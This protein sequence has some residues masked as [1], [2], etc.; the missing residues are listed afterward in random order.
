MSKQRDYANKVYKAALALGIPEPQ[1][2]LAAAQSSVETG[3]GKHAPGNAYFGIKAGSS[4][5]GP[6][7]ALNT[8]EEIGG[9]DITIKDAF[10]VYDDADASLADWWATLQQKWPDAATAT[11]F[12]DAVAGLKTGIHGSYATDSDYSKIVKFVDKTYLPPRPPMNIP[13]V[14]SATS[15]NPVMGLAGGAAR[16]V[17]PPLPR[18]RPQTAPVPRQRPAEPAFKPLPFPGAMKAPPAAVPPRPVTTATWAPPM[19]QLAPGN[20]DLNA[21]RVFNAP[22][23]S[24]RTENSMSIGTDAGEVLIPTVVNGRQLSEEQAIE[25]YMRTGESLGTFSSPDA[26]NRYAQ[27]L[28]ERQ[29]TRYAPPTNTL[30]PP[31][32]PLNPPMPKVSLASWPSTAQ[33]PVLTGAAGSTSASG[34]ASLKPAPAPAATQARTVQMAAARPANIPLPVT[35]APAAPVMTAAQR[36]AL[37]SVPKPSPLPAG[38]GALVGG[39]AGVVP[40]KVAPVPLPRPIAAPAA[41][42]PKYIPPQTIPPTA[43]PPN[44]NIFQS[45]F[46]NASSAVGN[47]GT[48]LGN[49]LNTAKTNVGNALPGMQQAIMDEALKAALGT[50]PGRTAIIDTAIKQAMT[51]TNKPAPPPG[52]PAGYG[53]K[54]YSV[55]SAK[56]AMPWAF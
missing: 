48:S 37:A 5:D 54:G 10:R 47:M 14:A 19:G 26:A 32:L 21:R 44:P 8:R 43:A 13:G 23:G 22:D 9:K 34:S 46:N 52:K 12:P 4:W 50:I 49:T 25:H 20:L 56:A 30:P 28:H 55:N 1:A 39:A 16:A 38:I 33:R 36:N 42:A 7:Q 35:N 27:T 15:T 6:T 40:P 29:A 45:L 24:Y 11:S 31:P 3:Y 18:P 51:S 2:R 53:S 17:P 41:P